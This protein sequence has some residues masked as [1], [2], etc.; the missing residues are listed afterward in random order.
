MGGVKELIRKHAALFYFTLAFVISW[1]GIA[2]IVGPG[3]IPGT[4]DS[5]TT[6]FPFVYLAM[7]IG[8]SLGGIL[9][10]GLVDGRAGY[11]SYFSRLIRLRVHFRWYLLTFVAVPLFIFV[12]LLLLSL[13][14]PLYLPGLLI[15]ENKL[16]LII[17]GL[18]IGI[19]AGLFEELG[20]TGFVTPRLRQRYGVLVTGLLVGLLWGVWHFLATFWGSGDAE[21]NFV[22]DLFWA[23]F[24]FYVGVLPAYRTLMVWVHDHT[25]SM[26]MAIFM[27]G[28]LTACTVVVL[29]PAAVGAMLAWYY[30]VLTVL[31]WIINWVLLRMKR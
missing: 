23:P 25:G 8:P 16:G 30:I 1:G 3:N 19:G 10:T 4:S 17:S 24:V 20:W 22:P 13:I 18:S 11:R 2:A 21:G 5:A 29:A 27:H 9:L 7:L 28:M 31:L 15:A 14:S 6:L 12:L 26:L